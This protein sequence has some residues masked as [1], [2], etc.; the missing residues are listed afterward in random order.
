M[1]IHRKRRLP[2]QCYNK[3]LLVT[4]AAKISYKYA[5]LTNIMKTC[6]G[7]WKMN[8]SIELVRTLSKALNDAELEN[9]KVVVVPPYTHI[10]SLRD[11]LSK[12]YAVGAQ[13]VV[14]DGS[15][16]SRTGGVSVSLI[17]DIGASA[18][19]VGHSERKIYFKEE[20]GESLEQMKTSLLGGLDVI[21][22]VGETEEEKNSGQTERVIEKQMEQIKKSLENIR[23]ENITAGLSVAYE[24]IWAIG[25]GKVPEAEEIGN[26][27][28]KIRDGLGVGEEFEVLY[29]GSVT[30]KNISELLK[31][32][33]VSGFLI[34][35]ASLSLEFLSICEKCNG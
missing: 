22:C 34:G 32:E 17:R 3:D 18:V 27:S 21:M 30:A 7:N 31:V 29:G 9:V 16:K 23:T 8:G 28:K 15:S 12:R 35:N 20:F 6:V 13:A 10:K 2:I 5:T 14:G 11:S 4:K 26:V 19:I 24:P 25:T 1:H 33:E